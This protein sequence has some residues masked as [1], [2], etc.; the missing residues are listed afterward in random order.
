MNSIYNAG[1]KVEVTRSP[2]DAYLVLDSADRSSS[3]SQTGKPFIAPQTQP[4]N[5]FRLQKPENMVQGGFSRI[6]LTEVNFPYAI[7]NINPYTNSFWIVTG[8]LTAKITFNF[9]GFFDGRSL[10]EALAY[11]QV[12]ATPAGGLMNTNAIIGTAATGITWDVT[13]LPNGFTNSSQGGG[14]TMSGFSTVPVAFTLYP[15]D[16]ATLGVATIPAK[17]MLSIMGFN[18][19]TNWTYLTTPSTLKISTFAPMSYTSYIDVISNKLTYWANVKDASTKVNSAS[20]IICRLYISNDCSSSGAVGYYYNPDSALISKGV[21]YQVEVPAGS[22]PFVIH[23]QFVS[24]KQF[25]WDGVTAIDW[26]DIQLLDDV[27]Q[28]LYFPAEGLPDFQITFKCT[29]D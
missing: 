10:A 26:I 27:G 5:N 24:P 3:S 20:S 17:S 4:Y 14:F 22:Q 18:P 13:Y 1:E 19:F 29:E 7:P 9:E 8:G 25:R 12:G 16:P 21:R 15:F 11:P 6:Q 23:R 28:P 2:S